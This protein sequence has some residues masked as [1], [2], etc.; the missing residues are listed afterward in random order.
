MASAVLKR[1]YRDYYELRE[2]RADFGYKVCALGDF[3]QA[4]GPFHAIRHHHQSA[5]ITLLATARFSDLGNRSSFF[6][7]IW[8]FVR[9]S[10]W[11]LGKIKF[12]AS[13]MGSV[14]AEF[15]ICRHLKEAVRTSIYLKSLG[16]NGLE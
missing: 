7:E 15:M 8:T 14:L 4:L 16:R 11:H 13:S 10:W 2:T 5:H 6:D 9:P 3:V 1:D 12:K